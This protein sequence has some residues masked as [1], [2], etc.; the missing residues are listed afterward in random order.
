MYQ[1]YPD[2]VCIYE[3]PYDC[4]NCVTNVVKSVGRDIGEGY[5]DTIR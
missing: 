4:A 2:K 1:L 3:S 5:G